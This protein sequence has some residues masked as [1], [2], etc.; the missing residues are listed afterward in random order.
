MHLIMH[1]D[2]SFEFKKKVFVV[3]RWIYRFIENNR[4]KMCKKISNFAPRKYL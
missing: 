1:K 3:F 4:L 2:K